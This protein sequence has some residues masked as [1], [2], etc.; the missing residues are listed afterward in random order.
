MAATWY[1]REVFLRFCWRHARGGVLRGTRGGS[2]DIQEQGKA[3]ER[4][5]KSVNKLFSVLIAAPDRHK[6]LSYITLFDNRE[7][8]QTQ[9][10]NPGFSCQVDDAEV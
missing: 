9:N 3:R 7:E 2:V 6:P 10:G 5:A 1:L 4:T 8:L